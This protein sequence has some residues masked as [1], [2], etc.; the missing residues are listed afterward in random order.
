MYP[1]SVEGAADWF[2]A[3]DA[4]EL[5]TLGERL[6]ALLDHAV[7][8]VVP[9]PNVLSCIVGELV[10]NLVGTRA[11]VTLAEHLTSD[12]GHVSLHGSLL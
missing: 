6:L 7:G 12:L 8:G 4:A 10:E 3:D 9:D 2:V 1:L 5:G 11:A